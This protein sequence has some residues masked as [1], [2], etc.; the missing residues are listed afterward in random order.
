L[1]DVGLLK[2][3]KLLYYCQGWHLAWTGQPMFYEEIEAW[4]N[5]PVVADFWHDE[6]KQRIRPP[7]RALDPHAQEIVRYVVARYGSLTGQE[8]KRL[9]HLEPPWVEASQ[10]DSESDWFDQRISQAS[11]KRFFSETDGM[12]QEAAEAAGRRRSG[13]YSWK[14][15]EM[16][17]ARRCVVD[18]AKAARERAS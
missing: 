9:T 13:H 11:L 8:L 12:P 1:A 7:G 17:P 16:T 6:D 4:S 10:R 5:G 2:V 3:H 14:E 15:M 18:E